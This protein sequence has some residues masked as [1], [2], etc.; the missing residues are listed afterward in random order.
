VHER[1][2]MTDQRK[3]MINQQRRELSRRD[4]QACRDA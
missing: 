2:R 1:K 3:R 4:V